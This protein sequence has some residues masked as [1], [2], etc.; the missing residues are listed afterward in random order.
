MY[1]TDDEIQSIRS[2]KPE[3]FGMSL[4]GEND[5]PN[6]EIE[7]IDDEED[8]T[9]DDDSEDEGDQPD[10]NPSSDNEKE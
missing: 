1:L 4:N 5:S 2:N 3:L 6:D 7:G 10:D 8:D 9:E